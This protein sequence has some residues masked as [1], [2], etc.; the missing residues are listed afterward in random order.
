[1]FNHDFHVREACIVEIHET[2]L[3]LI[4]QESEPELFLSY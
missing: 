4:N 3:Q 1:M 2:S